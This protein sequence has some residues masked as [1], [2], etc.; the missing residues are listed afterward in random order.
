MTHLAADHERAQA[1]VA[2][3]CREA[4]RADQHGS[5]RRHAHGGLRP[6]LGAR[7]SGGYASCGS[8]NGRCAAAHLAG[9]SRGVPARDSKGGGDPGSVLQRAVVAHGRLLGGQGQGL[10][11]FFF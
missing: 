10:G 1:A 11:V 7:G 9:G 4:H 3:C 5:N 8:G 2:A 6:R